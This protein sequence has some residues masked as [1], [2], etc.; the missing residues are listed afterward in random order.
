MRSFQKLPAE[1]RTI[2]FYSEGPAYWVHL[3]PIIRHLITDQNRTICYLSSSA[4]DPGLA[5]EDERIRPF[6]IGEK[7]VRTMLFRFL[8]AGV[9]VMTMPDLQTF[10]I[11]RSIHPVHYVNVFHSIVSTHMT[12]RFGAFDHFDTIFCVGPHHVEEIRK[13]ER[14]YNLPQKYLFE[15]GYGRLDEILKRAAIRTKPAIDGKPRI[16]IAPSWGHHGLLE[17]RGEELVESLLAADF[18]VTVRPHPETGKKTPAVLDNLNSRY[19]DHAS[20]SLERDVASQES[21]HQSHLMISDWSGAALDF[22]LGLLRPVLFVD[23]PRKVNNPNYQ[24]L[25]HDPLEVF[26][27]SEIGDVLPEDRMPEAPRFAKKLISNADAFSDRIRACRQKWV[28]N[29]GKSGMRGAERI[30]DLADRFTVKHG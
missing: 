10:H 20:F 11:K 2:V 14:L 27:R 26:I 16:L 13:T 9:M 24:E 22:A 15:H 28:Y 6:C 8:K 21:L 25:N 4:D 18:R 7:E 23:V 19:Q 3:E 29:V 5:Q 17:S 30:A 12:Y 1:H